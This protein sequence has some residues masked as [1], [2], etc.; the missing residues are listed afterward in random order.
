MYW[1]PVVRVNETDLKR[2]EK[3]DLR[4]NDYEICPAGS[5]ASEIAVYRYYD[6]AFH[7]LGLGWQTFRTEREAAIEL[8]RALN[9]GEV[10]AR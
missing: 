4:D 5:G 8:F 2:F 9:S 1:R 6:G 7:S 10:E 3:E